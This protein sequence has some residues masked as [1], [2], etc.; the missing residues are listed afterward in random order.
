MDLLLGVILLLTTV[1]VANI[2]HLIY[3]KIPLSIYQ[4]VAGIL[5]ASLPTAAT[6]FTMH[7]ELFMMVIIAPLM[8]NDGQNQSYHY[9]SRNFR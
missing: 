9:L 8:F 3:P 4:I 2:I 7:P 1:V 5:L 6:N